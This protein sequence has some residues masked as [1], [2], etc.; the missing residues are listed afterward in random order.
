MALKDDLESEVAKIFKDQWKTSDGK[1]VPEPEDLIL[2]NEAIKLSATVVYADLSGST[3]MVDKFK[4][5]FSAEVYKTY[6]HCAAKL[7]RSEDGVVTAYDGDRIMGIFIGDSKNTSAVRCG[8]KICGVVR[9]IINPAIKKQYP[10]AE[11]AVRQ[12]V[13]VD[14]SE[15]WVSRTGVRGAN[16]LVWVGRAANYAAKLTELDADYP[17]WITDSVYGSMHK[18]VKFSQNNQPMWESRS[19]TSMNNMTIYRSNWH[20]SL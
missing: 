8:L 12:V 5:H 10:D 1:V 11:F 16:D 9:N 7:I 14:T 20:W 13:G 4:A 19:W 3:N 6:L 17:T 15:L 18:D 2:G